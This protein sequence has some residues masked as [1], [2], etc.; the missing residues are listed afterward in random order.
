MKDDL[1]NK[2]LKA[3]CRKS[4]KK[5]VRICDANE[6]CSIV[7]PHA[8]THREI[9]QKL[10]AGAQLKNS[11]DIHYYCCTEAIHECSDTIQTDAGEDTA[12]I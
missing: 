2:K 9:N 3:E 11:I 6:L 12:I 8:L 7:C 4:I 1:M 10:M 5:H